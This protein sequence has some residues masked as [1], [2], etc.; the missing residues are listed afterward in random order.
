MIKDKGNTDTNLQQRGKEN[1][2]T[3]IKEKGDDK[4]KNTKKKYRKAHRRKQH[5]DKV[6][7]HNSN[8]SNKGGQAV[9]KNMQNHS[10]LVDILESAGPIFQSTWDNQ[11]YKYVELQDIK[12]YD[13]LKILTTWSINTVQVSATWKKLNGEWINDEAVMFS[14]QFYR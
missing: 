5:M 1:A 8:E 4:N 11:E 10:A 6:G 14:W 7:L 3:T 12:T 2:R 9:N 13:D